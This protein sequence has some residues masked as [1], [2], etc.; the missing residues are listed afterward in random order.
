MVYWRLRN[1]QGLSAAIGLGVGELLAM[2]AGDVTAL[3]TIHEAT[4]TAF[5]RESEKGEGGA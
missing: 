3:L 1:L 2:D 5:R 4:E